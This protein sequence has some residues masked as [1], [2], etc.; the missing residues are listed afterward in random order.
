[1]Q[2]AVCLKGAIVQFHGPIKQFGKKESLPVIPTT[3]GDSPDL[4]KHM[5][6]HILGEEINSLHQKFTEH[7]TAG[8]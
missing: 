8:L 1:L 4:I 5:T 6:P 7:S 2:S 3:F